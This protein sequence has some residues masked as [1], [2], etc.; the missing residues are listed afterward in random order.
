M[1]VKDDAIAEGYK[2]HYAANPDLEDPNLERCP[3]CKNAI[4][5]R[6]AGAVDHCHYCGEVLRTNN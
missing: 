4:D 5:A 6:D 3:L 2:A 1:G